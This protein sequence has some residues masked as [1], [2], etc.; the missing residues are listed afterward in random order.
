MHKSSKPYSRSSLLFKIFLSL[1]VAAPIEFLAWKPSALPELTAFICSSGFTLASFFLLYSITNKFLFSWLI[2]L[3]VLAPLF[4]ANHEKYSYLG[5]PIVGSD[6]DVIKEGFTIWIKHFNSTDL[7]LLMGGIVIALIIL[8]LSW[9]YLGANKLSSLKRKILFSSGIV[10]IIISTTL[11]MYYC[12][13]DINNPHLNYKRL[14]FITSFNAS[15]LSYIFQGYPELITDKEAQKIMDSIKIVEEPYIPKNNQP[16]IIVIV[17]ESFLNPEL[18]SNLHFEPNNITPTLNKLRKN[19]PLNLYSPVFG[20][21]TPCAEFEILTGYPHFFIS[22]IT[23]PLSNFCGYH[24]VP[25]LVSHLKD[26]GYNTSYIHPNSGDFF[27]NNKSIYNLGFENFISIEKMQHTERR[28]NYWVGDDQML[29]EAKDILEKQ[30]SNPQFVYM[31]SI[32][33]HTPYSKDYYE[34]YPEVKKIN[35]KNDSLPPEIK[36]QIEGYAMGIH[37]TD[38]SIRNFIDYVKNR[39]KPTLVIFTPDH[40]PPL[41]Q[42]DYLINNFY[43]QNSKFKNIKNNSLKKHSVEGFVYSNY[44][45]PHKVPDQPMSQFFLSGFILDWAGLPKN[46]YFKFQE[47]IYSEHK[48]IHSANAHNLTNKLSTKNIMEDFK[49]IVFYNLLAKR[50]SSAVID[51]N[52]ISMHEFFDNKFNSEIFIITIREEATRRLS[53]KITSMIKNAGG[54]IDKVQYYGSYAA[55][56]KNGKI[57]KDVYDN[58]QGEVKINIHIDSTPINIISKSGKIFNSFASIKINGKECS[59]MGRGLAVAAVNDNEIQYSTFNSWR[60]KN[61]QKTISKLYLSHE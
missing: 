7:Y 40:L 24:S 48:I 2:N 9:K 49:N 45:L 52:M 15:L 61:Q 14:G 25:T 47:K 55:V 28:N 17:S 3:L 35:L 37:F 30:H 42:N 16:D 20:G 36:K 39:K 18:L 53:S 60:Y 43:V 27:N 29:E 59:V 58:N 4:F 8:I 13:H 26:L 54:N 38:R 50:G 46:K 1:L 34:N 12:N 56:F 22:N 57:V 44:D 19:N 31:M 23:N 21:A 6:L 32:Q 10:Y 41:P 51:T 11:T 5:V 33:N